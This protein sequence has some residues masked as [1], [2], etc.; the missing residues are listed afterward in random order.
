MNIVTNNIDNIFY[1]NFNGYSE[2]NIIFKILH[3]LFN[4]NINR[5]I[6]D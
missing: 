2:G 1:M 6:N 4:A 3:T 5:Q